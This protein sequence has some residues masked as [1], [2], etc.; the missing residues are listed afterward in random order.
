MKERSEAV[1]VFTHPATWR[2]RSFATSGSSVSTSR[3]DTIGPLSS[4]DSPFLRNL[5]RG[6]YTATFR[7]IPRTCTV[8]CDSEYSI[9]SDVIQR[10]IC[11]LIS[12]VV[13]HSSPCEIA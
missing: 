6:N 2:S 13:A 7:S 12:R 9:S 4:A 5:F 1:R 11:K 3:S 8:R 10:V